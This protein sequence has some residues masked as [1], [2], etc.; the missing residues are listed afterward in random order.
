MMLDKN[1]L[2]KILV[3]QTA[4]IG[5]AILATS[6]LESLHAALPQAKIDFLVRKGNESLFAQHP[7]LNEVLIWDKTHKKHANLLKL[8]RTIRQKRYDLLFNLQRFTSSGILTL[9][10]GARYK[11]GFQKNPLSVFF[12]KSYPHSIREGLH[13]INRNHQLLEVLGDLPLEMPRL[14]PS[15]AQY[16][17][18]A[19]YKQE[20]YICLA[21]TSVWFTKQF[22]AEQW[23]E[24]I[25]Q[26]PAQYKIY[27]LGAPS[28]REACEAIKKASN[29]SQVHNLAGELSLLESAAL[30]QDAHLNYV[31]DSAPMHLASAV[32]AATCA[33]FCSTV[34]SFGFGPLST[35]QAIIVESTEKLACRPCGLHGHK[36]CP[37]QHFDCARNIK[38][39]TLLSYLSQD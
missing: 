22:P 13:E 8:I 30:L 23:I 38:T 2:N 31:N 7:W 12:S 29:K 34:S 5:D 11:V 28:D 19:Q 35:R 25:K 20:S 21:P 36:A 14:Y 1:K 27:L 17:K 24:F 33:I 26:V 4:F 9:F 39:E 37:K 3:V 6:L 15:E 16:K 10:S 32:D 18:V